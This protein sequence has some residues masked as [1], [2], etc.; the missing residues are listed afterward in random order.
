MF[1]KG[2]KDLLSKIRRRKSWTHKPQPLTQTLKE[3]SDQDQDHERSKTT[4]S[5]SSSSGYTSLVDENE[6]LKKENGALSSEISTMKNKCK[7]LLDMVALYSQKERVDEAKDEG[8]KLFGV[9]LQGEIR[10]RKRDQESIGDSNAPPFFMS[11]LCK[12]KLA[13]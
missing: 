10:K 9:K 8:P 2:K 4:S 12:L 5:T 6:R 1:G 11:Q 7:E 3:Q 13:S